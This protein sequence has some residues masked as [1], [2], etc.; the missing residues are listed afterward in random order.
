MVKKLI[1]IDVGGTSVKFAVVSTKG[2]IEEKWSIKT[3]ISDAGS[4]IVG[5][6]AYS[7]NEKLAELKLSKSDITGIGMGTPGSINYTDGTVVNAFNL[8]WTTVQPISKS[9]QALTG[10]PVFLDN[11]ANVAALGEAWKGAGGGEPDVVFVTLGTGVGGGV[12]AN[13]RIVRGVAGAGGEIG[14]VTVARENG[15]ACTCGKSGCL[16]TIASATGVMHVARHK[17]PTSKANSKLRDDVLLNNRVSAKDV[18]DAAK[19]YDPFAEEVV[20]Y[21]SSALGFALSHIGNILNPAC[22]VIGGGVSAAGDILLDPVRDE[23]EKNVFSTVKHS[24]KISLATLGNDAGMIGAAS[25]VLTE[26]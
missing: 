23:F 11:D 14:H 13:D 1:G 17:A 3:N 8:N 2:E 4:H 10:L 5:D 7:L 21:V 6:I 15:F 18:F 24:T 12:I 20:A 26:V 25:L 16:E 9:L 19:G 22:I